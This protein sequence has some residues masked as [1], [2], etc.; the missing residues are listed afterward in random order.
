MDDGSKVFAR[1]QMKE[2]SPPIVRGE[3]KFLNGTGRYE[4]ITGNGVYEVHQVSDTVLWDIL[5]GEYK[6]P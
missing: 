6:L 3:W 4:G 1:Y 2:Y 5:E